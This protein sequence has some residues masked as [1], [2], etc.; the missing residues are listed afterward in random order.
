V[1]EDEKGPNISHTE[2]EK[3]IKEIKNKKATGD[4]MYPKM[5]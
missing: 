4:Y 5:Y 1:D 2:V 3:A